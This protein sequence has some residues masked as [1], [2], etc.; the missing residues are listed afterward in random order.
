MAFNELIFT[1]FIILCQNFTKI[2]FSEMWSVLA[3]IPV[4]PGCFAADSHETETC[5]KSFYKEL[6][7]RIAQKCGQEF[8]R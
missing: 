8:S 5:L 3:E 1:E 7:Y 4:R 2:S 6:L